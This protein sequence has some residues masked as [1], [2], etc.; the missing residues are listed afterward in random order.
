V[1]APLAELI[2]YSRHL[3]YVYSV[4]CGPPCGAYPV[5]IMRTPWDPNIAW[6][7]RDMAPTS[8]IIV[9][10]LIIRVRLNLYTFLIYLGS[11][12]DPISGKLH[13]YSFLI[14]VER[15]TY[16]TTAYHACILLLNSIYFYGA[17]SYLSGAGNSLHASMQ[18]I[19]SFLQSFGLLSTY[20]SSL[21]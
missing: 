2:P 1:Q 19:F 12:I 18:L 11:G 17:Q 15:L 6:I 16:Q 20:D 7:T 21:F 13:A 5:P 14:I 10:I 9:I 3:H 8:F 4:T